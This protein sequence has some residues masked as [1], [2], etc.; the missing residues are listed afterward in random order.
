VEAAMSA[1]SLDVQSADVLPEPAANRRRLAWSSLSFPAQV[2][3]LGVITA[4]ISAVLA[5]F[6]TS[7]SEPWLFALLAVASCLTSLWKINL[8]IPLASG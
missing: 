3:V 6:P 8:P 4:G 1:Q 2:Y 5:W 7:I